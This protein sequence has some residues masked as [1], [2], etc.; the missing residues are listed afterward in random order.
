M[1]IT[2]EQ[3]KTYLGIADTSQDA[4]IDA[5]LPVVEAKVK[6][7]TRRDWDMIIR[8][9]IDGTQYVEIRSLGTDPFTDAYPQNSW[10]VG[11][12]WTYDTIYEHIRPGQLLTGS[13]IP[14]DTYVEKVYKTR[15]VAAGKTYD[16]GTVK[17]SNAA[18]SSGDIDIEVGFNR[19]YHRT[20][21]KLVWWMI[22]DQSIDLPQGAIASKSLGD[23]SVTYAEAGNQVDAKFG[24]P[25]WAIRGLPRYGRGF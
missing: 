15:V 20:V 25:Q 4:A 12:D 19:A 13:G 1:I 23:I 5:M 9:T 6:E 21:A 2:R 8:G 14:D 16:P 18:T 7:I 24:V 17:I 10:S 3:I 22:Q 11:V